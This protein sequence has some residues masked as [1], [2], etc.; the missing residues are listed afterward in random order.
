MAYPPKAEEFLDD[1][2][3]PITLDD[4]GNS[5]AQALDDSGNILS[6]IWKKANEPLI[7]IPGDV[8]KSIPDAGFSGYNRIRDAVGD[9]ASGLTSPLNLGLTVSTLGTGTAANLGR[10]GLAKGLNY[11]TKAL[12][13]P[14]AVEGAIDT[15]HPDSS[16]GERGLGLLE[17]AGGALGLKSKVPAGKIGTLSKDVELITEATDL[18]LNVN[19]KPKL[20]LNS[21]GTFTNPETGKIL[22]KTGKEIN[23]PIDKLLSALDEAEPLNKEQLKIYKQERGERFSK[24]EDV[25]TP[26]LSG[27]HERLGKLKGEYSKVQMT[28]LKLDQSDVDSLI[29]SIQSHPNLTP[30]D[31]VRAGVGITKILDGKVPQNNELLLLDNI[32]GKQVVEQIRAKLPKVD[33]GYSTLANVTNLPRQL[34]ASFDLSAPFRQGLPL[35]HTKSWW[36]SWDDMIKAFGSDRSYRSIMDEITNR[37]NFKRTSI[38]GQLNLSLHEQAGLK[39]TDLA[40]LSHREEII[41]ST[42]GE[43]IPILGRGIRASNRAYTAFLNKLRADNFDSMI[44]AA[45]MNYE[46][47]KL[48]GKSDPRSLQATELLNPRT[49]PELAS[50]IAEYINNASGRGSLGK[51][52]KHAQLLNATLFS[53][54]LIASRVQ[55]LNPKNYVTG[56]KQVRQAYLKSML[57]MATAWTTLAGLGKAAGADVSLDS[58]SADFMK[59]KVGDTRLDPGAGF[60]QYLVLMS[61]MA[62]GKFTS[63]VSGKKSTL[64]EG[65]G[66]STRKDVV[67]RFLTSK[68]N[69][70]IAIAYDLLNASQYRPFHVGDRT[71][72][73]FIPMVAQDMM[74]LA[75]EDPSLIPFFIPAI[76]GIGTSTYGRGEQKPLIIPKNMDLIIK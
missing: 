41:A 31:K 27:L 68:L 39:L 36:T 45:D 21:D 15:L 44:K 59:I 7:T 18:P 55:M 47:Q 29:D 33:M 19:P 13:T 16:L 62:S 67:E 20:K 64:G 10:Q 52:E 61:R 3:N 74:E 26:G 37:P 53:P 65:F 6:S 75:Q 14:V 57:S 8:I 43:R 38:N 17:L 25:K 73:M 1:N 50:T 12:S 71:A 72:Q 5:A 58:N 48:I 11:A 42:L 63:S 69:P 49:N 23:T 51:L 56:T 2:G 76:A 66:G 22:D 70:P 35:V 28:P 30:I 4:S 40:D 34:M 60:Q 46:A 54:R 32:F 24:L 9:I